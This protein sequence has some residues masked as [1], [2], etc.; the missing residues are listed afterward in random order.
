[1][2]PIIYG[3]CALTAALCTYLLL[4]GYQRGKYQLLLW[5]GLCFAGLTLNNL[6]LVLD[7]VVFPEVDL[8]I[9]RTS[10]ALLAMA[11]LLYG[12]IWKTE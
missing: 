8:S 1:M 5:S 11:V 3:L 6:L 12:L 7:K 10:V 2:A 9:W 4:Q